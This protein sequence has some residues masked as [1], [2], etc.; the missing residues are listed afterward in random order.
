[1]KSER[2]ETKGQKETKKEIHKMQEKTID[3]IQE[4]DAKGHLH[5]HDVGRRDSKKDRMGH[6]TEK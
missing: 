4:K 2:K 3:K 5:Q 6:S 1:M